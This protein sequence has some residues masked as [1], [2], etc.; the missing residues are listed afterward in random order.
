MSSGI[1]SFKTVAI[2]PERAALIKEE[3]NKRGFIRELGT[4]PAELD[5]KA[6]Y[7]F[8]HSDDYEL[9]YETADLGDYFIKHKYEEYAF[10][11]ILKIIQSMD[12]AIPKQP[13]FDFSK[14]FS[15]VLVKNNLHDQ[16]E[17]RHYITTCDRGF[18]TSSE[19]IYT[20]L[21]PYSGYEKFHKTTDTP[22]GWWIWDRGNLKWIS[23]RSIK[24]KS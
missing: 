2:T 1:P 10:E 6:F 11:T 9:A 13:D 24:I 15:E 8:Y 3:L 18:M 14:P 16:W 22:K 23:K 19:R 20:I 21:I 7:L 12:Y 4:F 17:A 5:I